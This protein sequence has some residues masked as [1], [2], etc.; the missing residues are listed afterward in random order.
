MGGRTASSGFNKA[1]GATDNK[2]WDEKTGYLYLKANG[3][4]DEPERKAEEALEE[5]DYYKKLSEKEQA[6]IT[7]YT[8]AGY[9][10]INKYLRGEIR[11]EETPIWATKEIPEIKSAISKSELKVATIFHRGSSPALLGGVSTV[12]GIRKLAK[13]GKIVTDFGF[14]SASAVDGHHFKHHQII[15]HIKTNPGDGIGIYVGAKS[16]LDEREYIFGAGSS[17]LVKGAY[18]GS[19][20]KVHCNLEYVG[21]MEV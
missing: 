2:E 17:Y 8:G 7:S 12:E 4:N 19:D 18:M 14:T 9:E 15:Y 6:A 5:K 1:S 11:K 13:Q 21:R 10:K 20:G 16:W 3:V